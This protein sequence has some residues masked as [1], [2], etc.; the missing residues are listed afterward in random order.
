M[1][2]LAI[3]YIDADIEGHYALYPQIEYVS[4]QAHRHDFYE[5]F[6]IAEGQTTHHIN[7]EALV[8]NR[9]TL[10]FIRPDDEHY[11]SK[12]ANQ[13]CELINLAFLSNTF[14]ALADFIGLRMDDPLLTSMMPPTSPL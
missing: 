6:L 4:T 2:L 9:G 12:Y 14:I 13:N 3:D 7:G 5:I 11:Y 10:V 1:R 8:L